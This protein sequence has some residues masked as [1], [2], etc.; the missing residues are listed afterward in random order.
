M[1]HRTQAP[2][3][4]TERIRAL[5][6]RRDA[7]HSDSRRPLAVVTMSFN[8]PDM[9]PFWIRH[10]AE[11]VGLADCYVL[12]HGSTD[13]STDGL[14]AHVVRLPR[15][16]FDET[17]RAATVSGFCTALLQRYEAVLYTDVDELVIAD[18]L[19]APSLIAYAALPGLPE[20]VTCLGLDVVHD[21]TMEGPLDPTLPL[22]A[23]RSWFWAFP[24]LCKPTFI[25]RP[26]AWGI[27]FHLRNEAPN[28]AGLYL[29]H[30]AY[31]DMT[32]VARRQAKRNVSPPVYGGDHHRLEPEV[33]VNL[34]RNQIPWNRRRDVA[35]NGCEAERAVH[36]NLTTDPGKRHPDVWRIP[37]RFK[38]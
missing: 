9:L 7:S 27:G 19:V 24:M 29:L 26:Y 15:S 8:E 21:E 33:I 3:S 12:D 25:R 6:R 37:D 1:P 31:A 14:G 4:I 38:I 32:L 30:I 17:V 11:Q 13:G 34:I 20:V 28:F 22:M 23:Q 10:Y 5:F 16:D 2:A 36:V 35:L 18:P